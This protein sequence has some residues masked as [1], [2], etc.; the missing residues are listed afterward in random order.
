MAELLLSSV[1]IPLP[2]PRV[3]RE[4]NQHINVIPNA[5]ATSAIALI[6]RVALICSIMPQVAKSAIPVR[7][8]SSAQVQPFC[9]RRGL[10]NRLPDVQ[11]GNP[12][13]EIVK[14]VVV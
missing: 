8:S 12:S 13:R 1:L 5:C 2:A 9:E 10:K 3:G 4:N 11:N 6:D 14:R 7:C